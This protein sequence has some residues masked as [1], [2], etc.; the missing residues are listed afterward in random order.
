M[1][2]RSIKLIKPKLFIVK[3]LAVF[4]AFWLVIEPLGLF[5]PEELD[6][7]LLG[8]TFL[9]T[10]SLVAAFWLSLPKSIIFCSLSSPNSTITIKVGD[11]FKENGHLVIGM[12][13]VFDTEVGEIIRQDSIQG[14]FLDR[15]YKGDRERLDKDIYNALKEVRDKAIQD[16]SKVRGKNQRYPIGTT[17]TLGSEGHRYFLNAYGRMGSDLRVKATAYGISASLRSL[18]EEVRIKGHNY[19]VSIPV[20]ASG[21]ARTNLPRMFLIKM[22]IMSFIATS[23]ENIITKNLNIIIYDKDIDDVDMNELEYFLRSTCF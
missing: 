5:F 13:D 22:I 20:I 14:Q 3:F 2:K 21:L 17:I 19:D 15:I 4:G 18:W 12:N 6:F 11:I 8:Y 9:F 7:G 16:P 10:I 1:N 23:K